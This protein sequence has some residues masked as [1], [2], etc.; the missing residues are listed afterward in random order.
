MRNLQLDKHI[1]QQYK[2]SFILTKKSINNFLNNNIQIKQYINQLLNNPNYIDQF[3]CIKAILKNI[4]LTYCQNCNKQLTIIQSL[5]NKKYCCCKCA[6]S[7]INFLNKKK[8]TCLQKYGS[9]SPL[10]S[11]EIQNKAKQTCLQKYN[12]NATGKIKN[13]HIKA[14]NNTNFN[15][16]NQKSQQTCLKK[17]GTRKKQ[18]LDI[19]NTI[20]SWQQYIIPLFKL[21]DYNG[22][23]R[24][25]KWKCTK[26]GNIFQSKIYCTNHLY[27]SLG[28]NYRYIPQCYNCFP[29]SQDLGISKSEKELVDFCKQFY[30]NLIENN[31]SLIKPYELDILIPDIK[32]AI[33]FNGLYYHSL[34]AN[35]NLGYHLMKTQMCQ[36]QNYRLIHIWQHQW[37]INKSQIKENLKNIFENNE[38]IP[39]ITKFDRSW[40][41][42]NQ[43]KNK[44]IEILK[45]EILL[46]KNKH[47]ENCG[48]IILKN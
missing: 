46:I 17:Y 14:A 30:P 10:G 5:N 29:K 26:C 39:N 41:S 7:D 15:L 35:T 13:A 12:T 48:Y 19:W 27:Y 47:I 8:Q 20:Q 32:L 6:N 44:H 3:Q 36:K 22:K 38:I 11:K 24:I 21:S 2:I 25:Y 31:R 1:C 28:K 9:I 16:R 45:P 4:N 33:E 18:F 23:Q 42:I 37:N 43:F 34:E 40:Y